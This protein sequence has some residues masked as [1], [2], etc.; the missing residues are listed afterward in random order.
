M[1]QTLDDSFCHREMKER[2]FNIQEVSRNGTGQCWV[3]AKPSDHLS[4]I[5]SQPLELVESSLL[6]AWDR[7]SNEF[8]CQFPISFFFVIIFQYFSTT[9]SCSHCVETRVSQFPPLGGRSAATAS[10]GCPSARAWEGP[11]ATR[12]M[13]G[14]TGRTATVAMGVRPDSTTSDATRCT[15]VGWWGCRKVQVVFGAEKFEDLAT[16]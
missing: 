8:V 16:P 13:A 6:R 1:Y 3:I 5:E 12:C 4:G 9:I 15:Y 2:R 7:E 10:R 14:T 11:G